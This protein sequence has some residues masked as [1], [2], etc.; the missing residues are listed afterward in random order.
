MGGVGSSRDREKAAR[1]AKRGVSAQRLAAFAK[2]GKE[3]VKAAV[4]RKKA[5]RGSKGA[6]D[7][8]F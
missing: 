3:G 6:D 1:L 2:L 4:K 5:E 8:P 7:A